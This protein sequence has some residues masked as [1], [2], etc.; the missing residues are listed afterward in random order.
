MIT[1]YIKT[2]RKTGLKYFGKTTRDN[3]YRY[4]GSGKYWLRH[5]KKYGY[6]V[7]TEII[8]VFEN[9]DEATEFALKFSRDNN[10]VEL[11]EW[12]NLIEENGRD[13]GSPK[14]RR[15]SKEHIE[16]IR[17][18]HKGKIISEEACKNMSKSHSQSWIVIDPNGNEHS[19]NNLYK[20]CK[21]NKLNQGNMSNV[22]RGTYKQCKGWKC[23]KI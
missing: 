20:F 16:K 12:A 21:E 15:K 4:R 11:K 17:K 23:E 6:D 10:I 5:I 2:H 7:E 14:G 19:V 8:G 13:G 3:V 1:L 18:A 22:A 9:I